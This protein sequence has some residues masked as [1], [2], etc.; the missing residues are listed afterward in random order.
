MKLKCTGK[1]PQYGLTKTLQFLSV[2]FDDREEA[3]L[4][5]FSN[6]NVRWLHE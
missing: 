1:L 2:H 5:S 4:I 3:L 6:M